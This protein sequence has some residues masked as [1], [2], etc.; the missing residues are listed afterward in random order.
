MPEKM[1]D[2]NKP[3]EGLKR[4][5]DGLLSFRSLGVV[6]AVLSFPWI[7]VAGDGATESLEL[8]LHAELAIADEATEHPELAEAM[9]EMLPGLL[10]EY[11]A[12]R[13]ETIALDVVDTAFVREQVEVAKLMEDPGLAWALDV[14]AGPGTGFENS[15]H[16]SMANL[17]DF[18]EEQAQRATEAALKVYERQHDRLERLEQLDQDHNEAELERFEAKLARASDRAD[19]AIDQVGGKAAEKVAE[20]AAEKVEKAAEK[21]EAKAEKA[22]EKAEEKTEKAEEKVE[23]DEEKAEKVEKDKDEKKDTGDGKKKDD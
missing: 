5:W 10:L 19:L 15:L 3:S 17:A 18:H 20:K 22:V 16:M 11:L 4:P 21:A 12:S 8:R 14:F 6:V 23:K 2:V 1:S 9:K 13:D 7:A